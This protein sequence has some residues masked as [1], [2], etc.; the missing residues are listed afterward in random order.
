[1]KVLLISTIG[2]AFWAGLFILYPFE[3]NYISN[4][5]PYYTST[6]PIV[7]VLG[8]SKSTFNFSLSAA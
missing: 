5:S 2:L 3:P 7:K 6:S 8:Y 1:M 4:I